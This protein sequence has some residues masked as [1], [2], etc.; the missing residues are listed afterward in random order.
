MFVNILLSVHVFTSSQT[1][2]D[3]AF[4]GPTENVICV[5]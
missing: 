2:C 5:N 3:G 4:L 1:G